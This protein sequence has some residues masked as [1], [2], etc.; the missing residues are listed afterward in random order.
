MRSLVGLYLSYLKM[1]AV[2]ILWTALTSAAYGFI[3]SST[4]AAVAA[5]VLVSLT[6]SSAVALLIFDLVSPSHQVRRTLT[7][8]FR[9]LLT[10]V[11]KQERPS[12]RKQPV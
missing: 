4:V 2:V 12:E 3:R 5:A 6:L 10:L 7:D 1:A 11:G 8:L 9:S